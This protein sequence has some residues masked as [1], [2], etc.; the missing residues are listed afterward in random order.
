MWNRS[1]ITAILGERM[2]PLRLTRDARRRVSMLVAEQLFRGAARLGAMHP[3]AKP[4]RHGVVVDRDIAYRDGARSAH[5]LD[6][7]RPVR[8]SGPRPVVLYV[9]GGG[10]R[11]LSKDSHWLMGLAFARE[12]YVVCNINYRLAPRHPFPAG[13]ED[14]C[15]ALETQSREVRP[16]QTP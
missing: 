2:N 9:H 10:F 16:K 13:I 12:G 5:R 11:M 1:R 6:V 3:S 8:G 4:E 7:Y 15:R 14:V